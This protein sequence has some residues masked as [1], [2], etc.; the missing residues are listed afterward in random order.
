MDQYEQDIISRIKSGNKQA[1]ETLFIDYYPKLTVFAKKYL[2]D[3]DTSREIVQN[4]FVKLFENHSDIQIQTSLKSYLYSSIRN[5]CLNYLNQRKLHAG[6]A[7]NI[8]FQHKENEIDFTDTMEQTELEYKIWQEVAGLPDQCK[9]IFNLSRKEGLKNREI[10]NQLGISKRTVETHISKA[11]KI[12]R[13][14]LN[15]Y[16]KTLF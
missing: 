16:L 6:H 8:K 7:D 10:A 11:L 2:N 4:Y 13:T 9:R 14:N 3:L 1:F 12:L 5:S 15:Q